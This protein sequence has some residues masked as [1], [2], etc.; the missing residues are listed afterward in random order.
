MAAGSTDKPDEA[1]TP[2]TPENGMTAAMAPD[3]GSHAIIQANTSLRSEII[4]M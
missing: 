3:S 2:C 1:A 4:S